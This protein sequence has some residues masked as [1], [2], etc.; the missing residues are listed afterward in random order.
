M[1]PL[2]SPGLNGERRKRIFLLPPV[3]LLGSLLS[4]QTPQAGR[5]WYVVFLRLVPGTRQNG[6]LM[7]GAEI[8]PPNGK[9]ILQLA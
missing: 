6:T 1:P 4:S 8:D 3:S 9:S 7:Y 5:K 2:L